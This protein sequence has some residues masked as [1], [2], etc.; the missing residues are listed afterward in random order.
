MMADYLITVKPVDVVVLV[1][2]TLS[3][4]YTYT[5]RVCAYMYVH[6]KNIKLKVL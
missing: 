5:S 1:V 3:C 6:M 2:I 4:M